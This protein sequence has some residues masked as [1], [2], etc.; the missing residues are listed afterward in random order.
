MSGHINGNGLV[1]IVASVNH[2]PVFQTGFL[3]QFPF[4]CFREQIYL[5]F[6]EVFIKKLA[7]NL[8]DQYIILY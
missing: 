3:A 5:M 1:V 4:Q 8:N 6:L 2:D 7:G